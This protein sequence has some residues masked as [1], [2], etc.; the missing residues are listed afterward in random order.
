[1][2]EIKNNYYGTIPKT[3]GL[4][5]AITDIH[6]KWTAQRQEKILKPVFEITGL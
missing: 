5:K 1:M 2:K 3:A 6:F 4:E